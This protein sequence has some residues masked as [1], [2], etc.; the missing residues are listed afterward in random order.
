M[1]NI[2]NKQNIK[3]FY[4]EK[5]KIIQICELNTILIKS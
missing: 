3:T 2:H 5:I 4:F 1:M